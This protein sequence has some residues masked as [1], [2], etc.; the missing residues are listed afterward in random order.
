MYGFCKI[1]R[2]HQMAAKKTSQ[3]ISGRTILFELF[4]YY[5]KRAY[6]SEAWTLLAGDIRRLQP[7]HMTCQRQM[8][9]VKWCDH[10]KNVD[11]A[12]ATDGLPSIDEI[13]WKRRN[14]PPGHVVR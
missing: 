11:V 12:A 9:G 6:A 8:L 1:L 5:C 14:T 7:F 13:V 3:Q 10:V 4:K 2:R